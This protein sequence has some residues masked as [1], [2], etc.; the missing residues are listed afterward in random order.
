[1]L[2]DGDIDLNMLKTE[3]LLLPGIAESCNRDIIDI[4]RSACVR[5]NLI[6]KVMKV[7]K[8]IMVMPARNATSERSFSALKRL[9]TYMRS[10]MGHSRLNNLMFIH[11]H[12]DMTDNM[13]L[14]H[15]AKDFIKNR[16]DYRKN[17]FGLF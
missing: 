3:L 5:K 9:K 13:D 1:M 2:A 6:P 15:V 12:Q 10:S 7:A 8:L 16:E 11:I 4:L 17:I 14:N